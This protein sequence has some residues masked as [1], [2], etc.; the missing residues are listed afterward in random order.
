MEVLGCS[1]LLSGFA[2]PVFDSQRTFR[3]ILKAVSYPGRVIPLDIELEAPVPLYPTTA[4]LCLTLLD[5][6]TPLW[7]DGGGSSK[8]TEWLRFHTGCPLVHSPSQASFGLILK[9]FEEYSYDQFHIGE[10]EFPERSATLMI[11]VSDFEAGIG[12][13]FS[14]PGI[15]GE[16]RLEIL[17]LPE[18]FWR[19]WNRN[20]TLYP[21]GVDLFFLS[22]SALVGL[23]RTIEVKE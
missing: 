5:P 22:P 20:Q 2:D 3:Q 21:L 13:C 19:F 17:G 10:E 18:T 6:E 1:N 4:A 14:G 12:R 9:A 7:I 8:L 15:K 11:Q 16:E 23:P